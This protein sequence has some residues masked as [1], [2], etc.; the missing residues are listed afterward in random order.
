M[1]LSAI[2]ASDVL[3][4]DTREIELTFSNGVLNVSVRPLGISPA[5][6]LRL[7]AMERNH[8]AG[9]VGDPEEA[10]R[11]VPQ[12]LSE[13]VAAWDLEDENGPVPPT[14]AAISALP[15]E[16][17]MKLME[18]LGEAVG[19]SPKVTSRSSRRSTPTAA[20]PRKAS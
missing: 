15:L 7:S 9:T 5:T 18:L 11:V 1:K 3:S 13:L 16:V 17:I 14:S 8:K 19:A 12:A 6:Q 4:Q 10:M 20:K 2:Q